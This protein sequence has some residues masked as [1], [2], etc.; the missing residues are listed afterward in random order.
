[1]LGADERIL[2]REV[3]LFEALRGAR[4]GGGAA[5]P[6]HG[7]RRSRRSTCSR[8]SPRPPPLQNYTKPHDA[9]R[10]RAAGDRRPPSGRRAPRAPT[11]SC[12]TTS[13]STAP[14][15]QLI[16]LTGPNMGGKSTYLRQTALLCLMA[17]AGSFVPARSAKLPIVDRIFARV[18]ASDNIA[19]GQSTFMV[20]MQE[21]A[22]HPAQRDVAQPASSSTRSAA[23]PR[24]STAS[25]SPGRSPS[26]SRR[27][28]RA[29]PK[30]IFATHYHELTDLADALP[31]GRQL[32]RRRARVEGRHRLP[33]QGRRRAARIAA[34]ASRWRGW[35]ACRRRS[36]RARAR[37]STGSSATSCRAADGRRSAPPRATRT[38]AART[39]P[40]AGAGRRSGACAGCA[41]LDVDNLTPMQALSL[42]AELKREAGRVTTRR[43]AL[44]R[45][46]APCCVLAPAVAA[47]SAGPRAT[48]IVVAMANSPINLDPR[49]GTDEASQKAHQLLYNTL[50]AHRRSPAGRAGARRIAVEQPDPTTYVVPL[51]QR[52]ALPQ[53][54]RADRRRRRLHVPQLSRPDV[55]RPLGRVPRCSPS[56]DARR[57]LHRR[58]HA[59]GAVR[60]V[61]HQ[62]RDGHR[63]GRARARP[64]RASRSAPGRIGSASSCRTIGWCSTPFDGYY[65]GAPA[66]RRHRAE[67]R[68]RRHDA[69]P[70]AAQGHGRSRRQRSRARHRLAAA[71]RRTARRS[72]PRR[73]R[74]YAYIGLNLRDP[75]L[76]RIRKCGRR[77]ATRS[78]ARRSCSYLRRGLATRGGRHRAADVV[79]V[80]ARRLRLPP[81]SRRGAAAARRGRLSAIR[82]ATGRSPRFRLSLKT[83]TSEVYRLQAAAIQ[84]D[85]ARVGIAVD[86]R[87][88]ELQTLLR[89]RAARQLPD[90]HAAVGR[91]D[92]SRHAAARLSLEADAAG[93]ARTACS[94]SN[95]EV[96]RLID[97]A[98][99]AL[100]E[101]ERA[102]A[103]RAGAAADRARTCRTSASGT[104]PTS[105]SSSPIFD[106]VRLSPI[107]DFTFLKDVSRAT[108]GAG[109]A[110]EPLAMPRLRR[111]CSSC[112]ACPAPACRQRRHDRYDPRLR[113]RTHLDAALRHP[114][115]QGEE[116]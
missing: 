4:R 56:V 70:R 72:R 18:G 10:R 37:S 53:R 38:R 91:R 98:A 104:R 69:R 80:R 9:R 89:R 63:A 106:G 60:V 97:A 114:L 85:L 21:T 23:A 7:A 102:P 39:V 52:R 74:D 33:A 62:P 64:M 87:S 112:V 28:P 44:D 99:A 78:I 86:V 41:A 45:C 55:P 65:G 2:E 27:T 14:T 61:P 101:D 100:D 5:H 75:M 108:A 12:R 110:D 84:H 11:R 32:P 115:H 49:V 19:R 113:F 31:I 8:R 95:A 77:S 92:R 73:A 71:R 15:Q 26:I 82:T 94:T 67:G 81:R 40:G 58:V 79:G 109:P 59:E 29:R 22:Q 66:Q 111:R 93:R 48:A 83:S 51:R 103:V 3:E 76:Q 107:A 25:A 54:P 50:V 68:A 36:W 13:R 6:G 46:R 1:M 96:D 90:V 30:T 88:S 57:S 16:I 35:P 24:R 34:T 105:P 47:R 17:Q 116:A 42:L 20:E 43:A